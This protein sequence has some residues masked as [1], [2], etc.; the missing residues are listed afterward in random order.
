MY[1]FCRFLHIIHK[2]IGFLFI[3]VSV[4]TII[5][6]G[7]VFFISKSL[8]N[9][10]KEIPRWVTEVFND[11]I[12]MG[13]I[14]IWKILK[15]ICTNIDLLTSI[16]HLQLVFKD[17]ISKGLDIGLI[18]L[19]TGT[20]QVIEL[21]NQNT[22]IELAANWYHYIYLSNNINLYAISIHYIDLINTN[23]SGYYQ[24]DDM[25]IL[26]THTC[27]I[28]KAAI[29]LPDKLGKIIILYG[30]IEWLAEA[31]QICWRYKLRV[32]DIL[33][34]QLLRQDYFQGIHIYQGSMTASIN[35]R[36]INAK[37]NDLNC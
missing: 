25:H 29:Q 6:A 15:Y 16:Q 10:E 7:T 12:G 36:G 8:E 30:E 9:S 3:M 11:S 24:L 22:Q 1:I 2:K 34:Q 27:W 20:F 13:N 14:S 4:I 21:N 35:I 19:E 5:L 37:I 26:Q 33:L 18:R 17:A 28:T 32:E 23:L 31:S